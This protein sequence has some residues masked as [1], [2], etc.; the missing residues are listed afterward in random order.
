MLFTA[1]AVIAAEGCAR[2]KVEPLDAQI[3]GSHPV[4]DATFTNPQLIKP[5]D[6]G[7][8]FDAR[9][10]A[11]AFF[12]NDPP[13]SI[14]DEDGGMSPAPDVGGT[15]DCP[16]DKNREG[17][18]CEKVGEKAAC[19]PGM[20]INRGH[21]VC[22]DGMTI[23]QEGFEFGPRWGACEGYRLPIE[24]ATSGA[25]AC[26]CFSNGVW[27]LSNLVPCIFQDADQ[28]YYMYS[29]RQDG[30]GSYICDPV[31]STP[32]AAPTTDW[33]T[34]TLSVDCGGHFELCYTIKA[35]SAEKP[36]A[37]DCTVMRACV[38]T[39]YPE[40]GKTQALPSLPGWSASDTRCSKSFVERGGYGEM[41]VEGRSLACDTVN[42]GKGKPFVF[43][44]ASYCPA[45]CGEKPDNE[46][47]RSCSAGGSG[48]F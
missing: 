1:A 41:T 32:P 22:R 3:D 42:D 9:P 11:D 25:E 33:T 17:C 37:S 5:V 30:E 20:R 46:E 29:S 26:R 43:Q 27:T 40:A 28:Q 2:R 23:C 24:G 48:N 34:S 4:F 7:I 8:D 35:G 15:P 12:I 31:M 44:R 38:E 13:P 16:D 14:C 10:S 6:G 45:N 47:C 36:K 19:W 39:F 21:G 18:P